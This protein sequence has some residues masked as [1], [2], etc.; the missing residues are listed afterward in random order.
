M[1]GKVRTRV[2]AYAVTTTAEVAWLPLSALSDAM[3]SPRARRPRTRAGGQATELLGLPTGIV[4]RQSVL[5]SILIVGAPEENVTALGL[6]D[7]SLG[8]PR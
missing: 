7:Q 4:S 8:V 3:L 2:S 1:A 6:G 5:A